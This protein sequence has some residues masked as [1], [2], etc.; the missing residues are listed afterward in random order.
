MNALSVFQGILP[1]I[2]AFALNSYLTV[3]REVVFFKNMAMT[4]VY[5]F[6]GRYV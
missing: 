1:K 5:R 2:P 6:L 4:M 3:S